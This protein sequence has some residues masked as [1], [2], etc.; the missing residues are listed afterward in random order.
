MEAA[1][2]SHFAKKH[3]EI[4]WIN[5]TEGGLAIDGLKEMPFELAV[6][7]YLT[8][9]W[10]LR[11]KI[12]AEIAMNPLPE[13]SKDLLNELRESLLRVIEHL[14]ILA[15]NKRGSAALAEFELKEELATSVLFYDMEKVLR[16][17]L[18]RKDP[19][20]KAKWTLYLETARKYLNFL[21]GDCAVLV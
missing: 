3:P 1:S 18:L 16:Q 5:T 6:S 8:Q 15:G 20:E 7:T 4:E 17:S 21:G 14:E 10:D 13:I 11:G 12:S 19:S 9:Q 2:I